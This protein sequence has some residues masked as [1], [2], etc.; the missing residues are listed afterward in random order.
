MTMVANATQRAAFQPNWW[1]RGGWLLLAIYV[2]WAMQ[3][4]DI[5]WA[6][7]Q[8]GLDNGLKFIDRLFPP[9]FSSD[10]L[11]MIVTGL[12][13]SIQ[14][15]VIATVVGIALSLPIGVMAARDRKSV[16]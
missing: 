10:K 8:L 14:I 13:E 1:A 12:T 6:R 11:E 3:S 9:N 2:W 5:T 16:V 7:F 15:A 4:L